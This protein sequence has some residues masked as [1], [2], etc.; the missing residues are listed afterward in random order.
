M[1]FIA[2]YTISSVAEYLAILDDLR[3]DLKQKE[4]ASVPSDGHPTTFRG[5]TKCKP[6][7]PSLA[8]LRPGSDMLHYEQKVLLE[9]QRCL[10]SPAPALWEV[11]VIG[12]HHGLPTRFLDWSESPLVGLFFGVGES[13]ERATTPGFVFGTHHKRT[14]LGD[15]KAA[16][17]WKL[18]ERIF[19]LP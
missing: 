1:S 12:R 2:S 3:T 4:A 8:R 6:L 16:E 13:F 10:P 7:I 5:Q 11:A 19:L 15:L 14:F 18:S 17:P 9:L